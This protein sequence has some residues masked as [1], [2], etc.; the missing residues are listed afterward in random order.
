M[1]DS[2]GPVRSYVLTGGRSAAPLRLGVETLLE[3][4]G[5]VDALPLTASRHHRRLW[6]MCR[7]RLS[8]AEAAV[9]LGL[10]ISVTTILACDLIES[11][12]LTRRSPGPKPPDTDTLLEVLHGLRSRLSV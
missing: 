9:H 6:H 2:G 8:L 5:A 3:A 1:T 11:G 4:A 12:H 7:E 10:P